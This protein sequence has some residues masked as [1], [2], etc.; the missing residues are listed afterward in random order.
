MVNYAVVFGVT[1]LALWAVKRAIQRV[2]VLQGINLAKFVL[3][4]FVL[5]FSVN[6]MYLVDVMARYRH[7]ILSSVRGIT[8]A[9]FPGLY[10]TFAV[11]ELCELFSV[12]TVCAAAGSVSAPWQLIAT[13]VVGLGTLVIFARIGLKPTR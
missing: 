13:L 11:S 12:Q 1:A 4:A 2:N 6:A 9:H 5:A 3:P 8:W 7:N 10:D